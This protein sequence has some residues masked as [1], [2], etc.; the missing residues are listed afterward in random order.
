MPGA[1]DLHPFT[2]YTSSFH[3]CPGPH[4]LGPLDSGFRRNDG[5]G[6]SKYEVQAG[7]RL[8]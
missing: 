7:G 6:P 3:A 8:R 1:D 5:N 2:H 4:S